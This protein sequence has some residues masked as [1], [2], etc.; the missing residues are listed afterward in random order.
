MSDLLPLFFH[1]NQSK[2]HTRTEDVAPHG[3][4]RLVH[5]RGRQ[6]VEAG[7]GRVLL[8]LLVARH[9]LHMCVCAVWFVPS[10]NAK[11]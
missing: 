3:H 10:M 8:Q 4:R 6:R 2:T 9:D 7:L 1:S 11:Y 5:A